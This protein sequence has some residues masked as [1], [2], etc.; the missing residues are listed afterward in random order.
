MFDMQVR[1]AAELRR[2]ALQLRV[3]DKELRR[4]AT[5]ALQRGVRKLRT[6]IPAAASRLP[7]GYAPVMAADVKVTTSVKLASRDPA[8]TVKVW[9]EGKPHQDHR[10]VEK[11]D[12]GNLRHPTF[13]RRQSKWHDQAVRPGFASQPFAD[14]RPAILDEIE[15]DWN[16]MVSRVERG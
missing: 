6:T 2:A 11:I 1:G 10:D 4:A 5:K 9:A 16:A 8:I 12:A 14:T 13:G 7:S 15:K 3:E